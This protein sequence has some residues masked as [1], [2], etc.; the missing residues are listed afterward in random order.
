MVRA[1]YLL[2]IHE[3][4]RYV[5]IPVVTE[6]ILDIGQAKN[7]A[8]ATQEVSGGGMS[9]LS[10]SP[11]PADSTLQVKLTLPGAAEI[12]VRAVVCWARPNES[13]YGLRFDANDDGRLAV[14]RWI[15][16]YLQLG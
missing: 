2:V 8:A 13:L 14:R 4:R 3:L 12:K 7:L 6:A 11:I 9:V 5:R 15:D 1:T 10:K 16:Q